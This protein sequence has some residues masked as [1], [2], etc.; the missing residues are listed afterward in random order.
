M[1]VIIVGSVGNLALGKYG[2]GTGEPNDPYQIWDANDM[3]AIGADANDWDKHFVLMADIDLSQFDGQDGREKFN[4]IGINYDNIFE[5]VFDGNDHTISGFTYESSDMASTGLFGLTCGQIKNLGLINP[6]VDAGTES[7]VGSLAGRNDG[8]I[9]NCYAEGGSVSAS[10]HVGGLAG[11]N[12]GTISNSYSVG[13]VMGSGEDIGGL[14]G[15]NWGTIVDCYSNGSVSG[16]DGVGGLVGAVY[17][18]TTIMNSYSACDVSGGDYVGGLAGKN[19][20]LMT[21]CYS[22]G[23]V[24]GA[25]RIGG[26][27]GTNWETITYCYSVGQVSGTTDVGGLVGYHYGGEVALSFWN[28]ETSD[29][30]DSPG[31]GSGRTTEQM[32]TASTYLGWNGCDEIWTIDDGEYPR[33]L[34]EG[35]LG[36][37]LPRLGDFLEGSGSEIDPYLVYTAEQLNVIGLFLCEW[38]KHF[39]LMADIDLSGVTGTSFNI[40]GIS[41]GLPFG[42]VFDGN[43]HRLLNFSYSSDGVSYV[44]LFGCVDDVPNGEIRNL[45]LIAPSVDAGTGECV[46]SLVGQLSGGTIADCYAQGVSIEGSG[47]KVGG[48]VGCNSG[49]LLNC[50]STGSVSGSWRIGG[51]VGGNDGASGIITT[52]YSTASASGAGTEV[53]GLAGYCDNGTI[54]NCYSNGDVSG[55]TDIGGLVGDNYRASVT[56]CYATGSVAGSGSNVGGLVG[57]NSSGSYIKSFWDSTVNPVLPGIGNTSDPNV[58]GQSTANMQTQSTFTEAGWDFVGEWENGP[59][60]EWA[61]LP[62]GGYPILWWQLPRFVPLPTFSGGTGAPEDPYL[63]STPN[64]LNRIGHNQ[65]LMTAHFKMINDVDLAGI[66]FFTVGNQPIP[67]KGVFDGND[68]SVSNFRYHSDDGDYTGLFGHASECEIKDLGLIDPNVDAGT[69]L[70][71][72]SLAGLLRGGV[73]TNCYVQGGSLSGSGLRV[74]GLVGSSVSG[75]AINSCYTDTHVSGSANRVGGLAGSNGGAISNSYSTGTVMGDFF[76]GGLVGWNDIDGIIANSRST[77]SVSGSGSGVGGLVGTNEDTI[78][79]SYWIGSVSGSSNN[80]GGLAGRNRGTISNSYST[81]SVTGAGNNVGGLTGNNIDMIGNSYSTCSVSGSG[82]DIGGF[83]GRASVNSEVTNSF[84]DIDLCWENNGIGMPLPTVDMQIMKTFTD[85]GWDFA[86]ESTNGT[87]D[88]WAICDG[89]DYPRHTWQFIIGDFDGDE[90]TDFGDYCLLAEHW[91]GP[92]GSFWC[93]EGCD[94]TNDG[95]VGYD[96]LRELAEGWMSGPEK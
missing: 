93:G 59:S 58:I 40:I 74:G 53:G 84:W 30:W 71:V 88:I 9:T 54:T 76:V 43:H 75:A 37:P 36:Q 29:Q 63:I 86:G 2:G 20:G 70:N 11:S 77:N 72:G 69:G 35:L 10:D 68:H 7:D 28:V 50:Y 14:L 96:D 85:A 32:K 92:G 55:T 33:L 45:G 73:V 31:G 60:D 57:W 66:N 46:G 16:G 27:V 87:N 41:E 21:D 95:Y 89:A 80:V 48:L 64:D 15:Y 65:R 81:G 26:L 51:L 62:G 82:T 49:L 5:G 19:T 6:N 25:T 67:F 39:K 78:S 1:A 22:T 79:N 34:W 8:T 38:D 4:L 42:G 17:P 3:Q 24:S 44:G 56:N 12:A 61:E 94:L 90:D 13:T 83:V 47:T 23:R 52:C 18:D 91:L